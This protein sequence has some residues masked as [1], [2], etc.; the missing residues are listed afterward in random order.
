V[1]KV[2]MDAAYNNERLTI[3]LFIPKN[4]KPPFQTV[5]FFPGSSVLYERK[6]NMDRAPSFDFLMKTGRALVYPV[7]KSTFERGDGLESNMQDK[8]KFYRDHVI[9]W[10]QD[11]SRSLDYLATRNDIVHNNYGYYGVSWGS[12]LGPIMTAIDP[13]FKAAVF[14]I[15]G[16]TMQE[17]LPEVDPLNFLPR[18]KIPV[19]MLNGRNDTFFPLETSQKPMF[20]LL[21]TPGKDKKILIYD[22]GHLVPKSELMKQSLL[23]FDQYLGPVK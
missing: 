20:N 2:D 13:R 4:H 18:V 8:T 19:L 12:A 14:H 1:E 6:F 15:G 17:T 9:C 22:G 21:G 11:I 7:L 5:V 3:Y 16:L 23:W 10:S